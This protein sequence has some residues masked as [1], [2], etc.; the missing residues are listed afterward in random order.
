[1]DWSDSILIAVSLNPKGVFFVR[2]ALSEWTRIKVSDNAEWRNKKEAI[3]QVFEEPPP[4]LGIIQN[5]AQ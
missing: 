4:Q 3:L 5:S 1:L 2:V